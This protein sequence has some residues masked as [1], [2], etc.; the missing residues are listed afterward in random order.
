MV[1][2]QEKLLLAMHEGKTASNATFCS[3]R[4]AALELPVI[5]SEQYPEKQ[6]HHPELRQACRRECPSA[7]NLVSCFGDET[8]HADPQPR[9]RNPDHLRRR[10]HVYVRRP[11]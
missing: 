5:V 7:Q 1:D 3:C 6:R 2:M 11:R 10:I 9:R 8:R 4:A